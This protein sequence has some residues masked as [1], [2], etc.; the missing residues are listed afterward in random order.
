[1]TS[2]FCTP[3]PM[4]LAR[5]SIAHVSN[6]LES[7]NV[8]ANECRYLSPIIADFAADVAKR[9]GAMDNSSKTITIVA[10][11]GITKV[12]FILNEEF[13][14]LTRIVWGFDR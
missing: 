3:F 14:R 12:D 5:V 2:K 1:M 13:D 8:D 7:L 6:M 10:E 4:P 9:L 11:V